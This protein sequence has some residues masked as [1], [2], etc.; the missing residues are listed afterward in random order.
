MEDNEKAEKIE[1]KIEPKL[2]PETKK[3][4]KKRKEKQEKV[5]KIIKKWL[6]L[7]KTIKEEITLEEV[8]TKQQNDDFNNLKNLFTEYYETKIQS[9]KQYD[10]MKRL[11]KNM[12]MDKKEYKIDNNINQILPDS[13]EPIKNLMFL[14]RN[15][16]DYITKLVSLVEESDDPEKVDS[17]VELFCNQ[18]YDNI[19]IPNPEQEELL[20]LIY[21]LLEEEITPMNSASVDEF[22]NDSS[23]IGKFISSYMNK[24]ELKIFLTVLLNPLILSIE[25]CGID[26]MNM[27]L[28]NINKFVE[29]N[30]NPKK[31]IAEITLE[32][33]LEKIPKAAIIFKDNYKLENEQEEDDTADREGVNLDDNYLELN[34]ESIVSRNSIRSSINPIDFADLKIDYNNLNEEYKEE[35]NLDKIYD[36]ILSEENR[37]LKDFYFYLLEQIT[38]DPDI[39]TNAGLNLVLNDPFFKNNKSLIIEKYIYNFLFIKKKIDYLIQSLIDKISTIPYTIRCICKVISILMNKKFPLLPKYL[40]NSFLG[41]FIF[42]KCIFPVLNFENKNVMDSRIF[43][44]STK[45]CLNVIISVLSNANKCCLFPTTTDTEKTIFNY[46][47]IEIIPYLNKFYE[48]VIDIQLPKALEELVSK[49]KL[50]I[51]QNIDNKIFN[52]KRKNG[53]ETSNQVN[54]GEEKKKDQL[55]SQKENLYDYFKENSDEII[56]LE[57][58]CFSLSDVLF[59]LSLIEKKNDI[60]QELPNFNFFNKTCE[61]IKEDEKN[62]NSSIKN[63]PD[64]KL[65]HIIFRDDKNYELEKLLRNT[66]NNLS[67]IITENKESNLICKKIKFCIK[68][69]LKGLNLLN[70]KD[71]SHL[72]K[73]VSTDKFF[74][75]IKHTLNELSEYSEEND[76][77][78]LKWYGQYIYN[79]KNGLAEEYRRDDFE[80]L[81]Q[82]IFDEEK[83]ILEELKL[84]SSTII[85]RNGMN[86]RCAENLLDKAKYDLADIEEAKKFVKI[87]KF[88]DTEKIEVC[89]RIKED[90]EKDREREKDKSNEKE[91]SPTIMIVDANE[92][93]IH[94]KNSPEENNKKNMPSS[95]AL[96]IKDF[97]NKFSDHPWGSDKSN[98]AKNPKILARHDIMFADKKNGIYKTMKMYM[99][100]V[101]KKIKKPI[102]NEG[103]FDE[104]ANINEI[105]EK[106]EDHILRQTYRDIFPLKI[107]SDNNFYK[108]TKCLDWVTPEQLEIKKVYFNQLGFAI[109]CIRKMDEARS[110]FDKLNL[111]INAHNSINN[112]IKFSSGKDDDSGQDEMTP[113][114][115]YIILKAN[116]KRMYSNINYLKCFLGDN[117]TDSRGFLLSQIESATSYIN[118]IDFEQ[119]K[120]SKE[121][122]ESKVKEAKERYGIKS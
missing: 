7:Q 93:N 65:F 70:N 42:D 120:M 72:N 78:P 44:S 96:Y 119:L 104:G 118:N 73:A 29:K 28:N 92:C 5:E 101:K 59:I 53:K 83:S 46:Y 77:I 80:K 81:Y 52:F 48:K 102:I 16:Y 47:L 69:V 25:N 56:H 55:K 8:I 112:T 98:K 117:L 95:H 39:F 68:T 19:L 49:A 22:L 110:V 84:F 71:F 111:I 66:G 2:E 35:L 23:F 24:R 20:I 82:E 26:C 13:F 9:R 75:A 37:D 74:S 103:L 61:K 1:L 14:F 85:T 114:F 113:I 6:E 50:K 107:Q 54:N 12:N 60:F 62:I 86:L 116:P 38:N 64:M 94:L 17:L 58:I 32:S 105:A 100:I 87:E 122:Y 115:Q 121:E 34:R 18:F 40:R 91:K 41:K 10:I 31:E 33:F 11:E 67:T 109:S 21:K 43:S 88:I 3:I 51:E 90:N 76:Q 27:S 63:N 45:K 89:F 4:N 99:D 30:K 79:Y 106:I 36:K 57:S 108:K 97:I 15:N